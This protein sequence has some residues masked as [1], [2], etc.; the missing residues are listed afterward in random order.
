RPTTMTFATT[1]RRGLAIP[2]TS[3]FTWPAGGSTPVHVSTHWYTA[4]G[5]LAVW[6]GPRAALLA[7]VARGAVAIADVRGNAPLP[8]GS[9]RLAIDLVLEGVSWFSTQGVSPL[10]LAIEVNG[11][12][13]ATYQTA[14]TAQIV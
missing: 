13:G 4:T 9:Y 3:S 2:N 7:D 5:N 11:G 6:G 10:S 14:A 8:K 1:S 12:Y